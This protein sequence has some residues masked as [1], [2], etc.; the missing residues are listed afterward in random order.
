M[1]LSILVRSRHQDHPGGTDQHL[2]RMRTRWGR[3]WSWF[4]SGWNSLSPLQFCRN[5]SLG[6]RQ[7]RRNNNI[8][9]WRLIRWTLSPLS[10]SSYLVLSISLYPSLFLSLGWSWLYGR[11]LFHVNVISCNWIDCIRVA[12]VRWYSSMC[13]WTLIK[14]AT[15]SQLAR[16]VYLLPLENKDEI[17]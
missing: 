14:A 7:T 8:R 17:C 3:R 13:G 15:I 2:W 11:I 4:L 6:T 16:L 5:G 10:L 9:K 1:F 12:Y